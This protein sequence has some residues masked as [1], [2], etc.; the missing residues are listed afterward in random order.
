MKGNWFFLDFNKNERIKYL[1]A[2]YF[3][4]A[5]VEYI[6]QD[7]KDQVFLCLTKPLL[8][9]LLLV[10][11]CLKSRCKNLLFIIS[12]LAAWV[13]NLFFIGHSTIFIV[14]GSIFFLVYRIITFTLIKFPGVIRVLLGCIPFL[15][16]F[17]LFII[18]NNVS[19]ELSLFIFLRQGI[20]MVLFGGFVLGNYILKQ[21]NSNFLMV[22]STLFVTAAQF[23]FISKKFNI[24]SDDTDTV[25]MLLFI[26]GQYLLYRYVIIEEIK[27]NRKI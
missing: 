24:S 12:L 5:I 13:A 20:I 2:I 23:F 4:I 10:I 25:G 6:S 19:L 9:P 16:A 11:Y 18:D 14:I 21:N 8:M 7:K 26:I 1:T 15:L 22:I 3:F 27:H 17:V